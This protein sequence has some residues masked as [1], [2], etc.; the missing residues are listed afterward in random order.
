MIRGQVVNE[1][2]RIPV[3]ARLLLPLD[4]AGLIALGDLGISKLRFEVDN[5]SCSR[6][7]NDFMILHFR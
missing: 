4:R 2:G 7:K 1:K 5:S 6:I 3:K